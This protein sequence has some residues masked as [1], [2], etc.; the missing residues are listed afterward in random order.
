MELKTLLVEKSC[1]C[2]LCGR[3]LKTGNIMY[4]DKYRGDI[5]CAFCKDEYI[6]SVISEEGEDGRLLK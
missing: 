6:E 1:C 3:N 4:E 2:P 5:L